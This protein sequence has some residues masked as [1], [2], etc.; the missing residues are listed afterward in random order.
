MDL[1]I[2]VKIGVYAFSCQ[3]SNFSLLIVAVSRSQMVAPPGFAVPSK[4]PPPG[5]SS[6]EK[7]DHALET[8]SE[9]INTVHTSIFVTFAYIGF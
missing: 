6:R 1:V 2:L 9:L 3:I 5:F 8:S 7:I 4:A